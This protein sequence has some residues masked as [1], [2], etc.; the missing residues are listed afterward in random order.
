[1]KIHVENYAILM[2]LREASIPPF[3]REETLWRPREKL[4]VAV[5]SIGAAG[6]TD[7]VR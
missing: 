5:P 7:R 3:H 6:V 4:R 1:M 2:R